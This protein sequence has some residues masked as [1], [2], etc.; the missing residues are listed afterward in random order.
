MLG[1]NRGERAK[2]DYS[3]SFDFGK[4]SVEPYGSVEW[5]SNDYINY[6]YGVRASEARA[7]RLEYTASSAYAVSIGTR[8]NYSLTRK[9][10]VTLD[11]AAK[12][13]TDGITESPI[14][15]RRYLPALALGY[16]YQFE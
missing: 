3:R 14:V 12:H 16:A 4:F 9:Q 11:V 5:F 8:I 13:F 6:Y 15:G 7:G 1:G 2:I 10:K